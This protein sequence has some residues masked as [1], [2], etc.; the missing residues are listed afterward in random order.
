MSFPIEVE[1]LNFSYQNK[2]IFDDLNIKIVPKKITAIIGPSG[3]GKTT[4]LKL[5][6][7]QLIASSG[8]VLINGKDIKKLKTN[9]IFEIRKQM[10]M[11]FQSGALLNDLSVFENVSLPLKEH[12]NLPL[13]MIESIVLMKLQAVGLRAVRNHY[14]HQLSGGMLRRVALARAIALDPNIIFYDEPFAGQDPVTM[15]VLMN[16]IKLVNESMNLTSVIVSH[17]IKEVFEISDYVCVL[18]DKKVLQYG[19][20][21]QIKGSSSAWVSQFISGSKDGPIVFHQPSEKSYKQDL[22]QK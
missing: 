21:E 13:K 9:E 6:S 12:T 7:S 3:C 18:S 16:L 19:S 17:D 1:H 4:L 2:V 20:V 11:L 8:K 14:P 5:I 15:G 10:G 22:L